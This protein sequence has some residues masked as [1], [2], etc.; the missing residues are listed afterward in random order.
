[1]KT[2]DHYDSVVFLYNY[3][4]TSF[5]FLYFPMT[6][7]SVLNTSVMVSSAT[8]HYLPHKTSLNLG[9]LCYDVG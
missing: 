3:C 9:M 4:S 6:I 8:H 5:F 2:S 1:M 7:H